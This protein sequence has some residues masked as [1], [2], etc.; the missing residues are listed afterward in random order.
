MVLKKRAFL[1]MLAVL[2]ILLGT[3]FLLKTGKKEV[4]K[5]KEMPVIAKVK[6]AIVIDDLGY[7]LKNLELLN[8]IKKPLTLSVLPNLPNSKAAAVETAK[9]GYEII[10]HLPLEPKNKTATLE[11][12]TL[13]VD[14]PKEALTEKL[15][16][17]IASL[18]RIKGVS[19]HMGS[20]ATEDRDFMMIIF[21]ELKRKKLYFFDSVTTDK[22]VCKE[23]A[24]EMH[25]QFAER[26]IY[27]DNIGESNYIK[28]QLRRLVSEAKKN[29]SAIAIGH[30]RRMTIKTLAEEMPKLENEGVEFVFLSKLLKRY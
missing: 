13:L 26:N 28:G 24:K 12:G 3:F 7:S 6:V 11:A 22:S 29:G 23:L 10:M 19:N 14:M 16:T 20:K 15:N 25:M 1:T 2:I 9:N 5:E 18:S 4:I 21:K 17:G 30:D 27:L 8:S